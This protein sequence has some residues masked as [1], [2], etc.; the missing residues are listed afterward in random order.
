MW[1]FI[2]GGALM[3]LALGNSGLMMTTLAERTPRERL[4]LAFAILRGA[5]PVGAFVGPLV[6]GPVVD[7]LG[8]PVPLEVDALLM[9]VVV[10]TLSLGRWAIAIG[11][12]L[13]NGALLYAWPSSRNTGLA[14]CRRASAA[15]QPD[16]AVRWLDARLHVCTTDSRVIGTGLLRCFGRG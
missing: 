1:V 7:A 4:G 15:G 6:G 14:D 3:S 13:R 16:D 9:L 2:L 12:S 8:F 10:L 11:T 5:N